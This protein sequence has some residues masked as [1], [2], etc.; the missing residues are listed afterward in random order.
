MKR[1]LCLV[2][3]AGTVLSTA[4]AH[5]QVVY[6]NTAPP[7]PA[8]IV[9]PASPPPVSDKNVVS[10]PSEEATPLVQVKSISGGASK[11]VVDVVAPVQGDTPKNAGAI[12]PASQFG[13]AVPFNIAVMSIVPSGYNVHYQGVDESAIVNWAGGRPWKNTLDTLAAAHGYNVAWA[14]HDLTITGNASSTSTTPAPVDTSIGATAQNTLPA[15]ANINNAPKVLDGGAQAEP[16]VLHRTQ[17]STD[18]VH[19]PDNGAQGLPVSAASRKNAAILLKRTNDTD[20]DAIIANSPSARV[21]N[22]PMVSYA[23]KNGGYGIYYAAPHQSLSE[24]LA[25]WANANGWQF[26]D[27][28]SSNYEIEMPVTLKGDFK[29]VAKTLIKSIQANPAP[30]PMFYNGNNVLRIFRYGD[31]GAM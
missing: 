26:K 28:T 25:I 14:G 17:F 10:L 20:G 15:S 7:P 18:Q 22:I 1:S 19:L 31:D 12:I 23:P 11:P 16:T 5:A 29:E 8:P 9:A 27:D 2:A 6:V 21:S 30:R 4:S 3:L 13:K 24:V